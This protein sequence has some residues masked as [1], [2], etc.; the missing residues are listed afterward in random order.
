MLFHITAKHDH[1]T[2]PRKDPSKRPSATL[3]KD[4]AGVRKIGV[5][6]DGPSHTIFA[7]LESESA[8]AIRDACEGLMDI[9]SVDVR[10][11]REPR[12]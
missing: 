12:R 5:W 6:V 10:L 4:V 11:V 2:C 7:V 8:E 9:G 3:A 1:I